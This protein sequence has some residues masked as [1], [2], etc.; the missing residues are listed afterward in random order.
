MSVYD[1]A[2]PRP[3]RFPAR[4]TRESSEAIARL[5][6][7]R[8]KHVIFAQQN[9]KAIDSGVFHNDVIAVGNRNVH[10]YHQE[11]FLNSRQVKESLH[12]AW[13]E[14]ESDFYSIEVPTHS[15]SLED[16]VSS[17]LFNSQLIDHT[18]GTMSIVVPAECQHIV[19]VWDY[20]NELIG[21]NSPIK[22]I[23]IYDLKQSMSNGGGPACLRLRVVLTD[24]EQAAVNPSCLMN[25][26]LFEHLNHWID[27]HYRDRLREKDLAD[28][29][30]LIES[31][32]ALDELTQILAVGSIYEFQR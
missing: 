22:H 1:K 10:F 32:Q 9:P 13:A 17:Y 26:T 7:L 15:V 20:L 6:G 3:L 14:Q 4:Q 30:L 27:R 19:T 8:E 2:A 16:C 11:A 29:Q 23:K 28:P 25:E 24:A 31:R 12:Q 5:H 18:D 21:G